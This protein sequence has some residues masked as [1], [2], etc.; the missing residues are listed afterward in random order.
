LLTSADQKLLHTPWSSTKQR[1]DRAF[2]VVPPTLW[3]HLLL[4]IHSA[5]SV[6]PFKKLVK[7]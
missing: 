7:T 4:S 1:G 3:N 2:S 6:Q 5:E